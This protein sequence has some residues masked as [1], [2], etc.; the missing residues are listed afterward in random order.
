MI[1]NVALFAEPVIEVIIAVIP[2]TGPFDPSPDPGTIGKL[3]GN[4]SDIAPGVQVDQIG[5]FLGTE[6]AGTRKCQYK[7]N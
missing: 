1:N 4:F 7:K 3:E 5:E 6:I 2:V